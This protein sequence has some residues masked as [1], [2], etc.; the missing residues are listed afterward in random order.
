MFDTDTQLGSDTIIDSAGNDRLTFAD[1]T[2]NVTVN[3]ALTT[4]QIVNTNLTLTLNSAVS[5]ENVFGGSGDDTLIGNTLANTL[6]G[7]GGADSMNGG[8]GN[9]TLI[10]D[11]L[12]GSVIG[13][14]GYDR[15][16]VAGTAAGA[17]T[18][19]LNAGQI[20]YVWAAAS[21][22][23][24]VFDATARPGQSRSMVVPAMIRSRAGKATTSCMAVRAMTRSAVTAAT[25][26]C[27]A[28]KDLIRWMAVPPMTFWHSTT[29]TSA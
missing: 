24:N 14:V 6:V 1:S 9:D 17:V 2:N 27:T 23:N 20:E 11:E 29:M 12:D 15:V 4:A 26:I 22:F 16:T 21:T 7:G 13:G 25:I 10:I 19:N 3:L 5:I 8:D 18:L 28:T